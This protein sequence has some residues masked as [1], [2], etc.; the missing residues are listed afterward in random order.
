ME[1]FMPDAVPDL[2]AFADAG[3]A[4]REEKTAGG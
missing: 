1:A 4:M 3:R 2:A